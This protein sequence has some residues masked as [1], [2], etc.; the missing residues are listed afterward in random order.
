MSRTV[1]NV[2]DAELPA[3]QLNLDW[4]KVPAV[5]KRVGCASTCVAKGLYSQSFVSEEEMLAGLGVHS[6]QGPSAM[7]H[8]L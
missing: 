2:C 3:D 8:P 4:M 5:Q 7:C 1:E 6:A